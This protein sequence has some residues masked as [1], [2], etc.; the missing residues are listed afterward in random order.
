MSFRII[1]T[2]FFVMWFSVDY[3]TFAGT[4]L[5]NADFL[6]VVLLFLGGL[7]ALS[8]WR[9]HLAYR[10]ILAL[11]GG[12]ALL[13]LAIGWVGVRH[14]EH[15]ARYDWNRVYAALTQTYLTSL[16][17]MGYDKLPKD[18]TAIEHPLYHRL[19]QTCINWQKD[20][21]LVASI[22]TFY[23]V[24]D[25]KYIY[26]LGPESDYDGDGVA[27]RDVEYYSPPGTVYLF[28]GELDEELV[29]VLRTGQSKVMD[30][31]FYDEG[32]YSV[33]AVVPFPNPDGPVDSA[34]MIDYH[35]GIWLTHVAAARRPAV[36]ATAGVL[37]VLLLSSVVGFVLRESWERLRDAKSVV[38]ESGAMYKKL[39]DNSFDAIVLLRNNRVALCNEKALTLFGMTEE[40]FRHT[41]LE[42]LWPPTQPDG[43]DAEALKHLHM[44]NALE[45]GAQLFEWTFLRAGTE[46]RAE[47][48]LDYIDLKG[49]HFFIGSLRDLSERERAVSAEQA[50]KAKSEFLATMSHEIR[51]P[52]N[53][54][55]GLSD[56]LLETELTPKQEEYAKFI[57]ESGK[58]LLF[59][60]NDILDFSKIEAGKMEIETVEFDLRQ[61]T[62]SVIGI[63][64]PRASERG[65]ELHC[66]FEPNVPYLVRGDGARLR[67][68]LLNLIGNALKFTDDGGVTVA[69]SQDSA[70]GES[71]PVRFAVTDTGIGIPKE[72]MHRLFQSFSQV[73]SSTTRKYGGTGLGLKISERLVH[74]MG[75]E[76]GVYSEPG[77]GSTF[78]FTLP[79][80]LVQ[81]P[82][83]IFSIKHGMIDLM[84]R[85]AVV[86]DEN[87]PHRQVLL[88]R[89]ASWGMSVSM[90]SRES[91]IIAAMEEA[92]VAKHPFQLAII[93]SLITDGTGMELINE[94]KSRPLLAKT[95][96]IL[97]SPLT[98][99]VD[100]AVIHS[101]GMMQ[102]ITNQP[103]S[104]LLFDAIVTALCEGDP[105]CIEKVKDASAKYAIEKNKNSNPELLF[106]SP[107][108]PSIVPRVLV[109]ED[110]RVN[111]LVVREIL[112]NAGIDCEIVDNGSKACDAVTTG[113]FH[114]ILMDC[115]MPEM[116]G[117]AATEAIRKREESERRT[118]IPIIA[119]TANATLEDE[120]RCLDA[121]MDA[122]CSKPVNPKTLLTTIE[123]WLGK[124]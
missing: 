46:F 65:L 2:S 78:W 52:L 60:I 107:L 110:N 20:S 56:L 122:Y 35:G 41:S 117:F 88:D 28:Q 23:K 76:I 54:V 13:V 112:T 111:Q 94:I 91:E 108:G 9:R 26:I 102:E 24:D 48:T 7:V 77:Q 25:E 73:D 63:L 40:E 95:A 99:S 87:D 12:L 1:P 98:E 68:I 3:D 105:A 49:E 51:T 4:L 38:E 96:L 120:R 89:L 6:C 100:I 80:V 121:G 113:V 36:Y 44:K 29:E 67:Q 115:Q 5:W 58:S 61:T 42:Q 62:E 71:G 39:F 33:S 53:G 83:P 14:A 11:I 22:S 92:V 21:R 79:L 16:I 15:Q 37:A 116:D 86:A 55:I 97:L 19:L 45:R 106:A 81:T 114:L 90:F 101:A 103:G 43:T 70:A 85:L 119:L 59:L 31:P 30:F 109:A 72:R 93:D 10:R 124:S 27:N 74:L 118:R 69:V 82:T 17:D 47:V 18:E 57:Q 123:H 84:G 50:S 64:G 104:S 8:I 34:L 32:L 66:V 75:G